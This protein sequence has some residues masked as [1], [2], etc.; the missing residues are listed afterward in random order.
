M[1]H[2]QSRLTCKELA[3]EIQVTRQADGGALRRKTRTQKVMEDLRRD[4][5]SEQRVEEEI[6]GW[7]KSDVCRNQLQKK[8]RQKLILNNVN[9]IYNEN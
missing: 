2:L 6:S 9:V 7:R 3:D 1:F 4:V 8:T 5:I